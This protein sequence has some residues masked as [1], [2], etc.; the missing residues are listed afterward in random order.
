MAFVSI[1]RLRP[2][3]LRFL[4]G[5]L[6]HTW[7]SRRQLRGAPGFIGGYLAT[8]P[9]KALWTVTVWHDEAAM[10]AYRNAAPHLEAMP[11]LIGWCDEAAV[12]H[13]MSDGCAIP[14]PDEA[15]ERMKGGRLSKVRHPSPAHAA[16]HAWPDGKVPLKGPALL[17]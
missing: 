13:W 1:T 2:R 8:G 3:S 17:P 12:V 6:L 4:P 5:V 10:R 7:R 9:G 11:K 16:G 14:T 15:A